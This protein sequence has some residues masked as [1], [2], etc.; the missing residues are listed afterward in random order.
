MNTHVRAVAIFHLAFGA[1]TLVAIAMVTVFFSAFIAL[2]EAEWAD[3]KIF[4]SFGAML[5]VPFAAVAVA[6]VVAAIHLLRGSESSKT[7][8]I[9]I[10]VL[11]LISVPLGTA[12]GIY[13][14]WVL[15]RK[16]PMAGGRHAFARRIDA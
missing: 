9:V 10:G 11:S 6:Q 5:A 16:E 12:L 7:W 1:L 4:A 15:V 14:L 3:V 13:T 2:A 8:L